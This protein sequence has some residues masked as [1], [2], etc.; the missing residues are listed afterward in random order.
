MTAA[1][2][3]ASLAL[4]LDVDDRHLLTHSVLLPLCDGE[5]R[6]MLN[7]RFAAGEGCR[8][9]VHSAALGA[10]LEVDVVVV[11]CAEGT[12]DVAVPLELAEQREQLRA[13]CD[14]MTG[15]KVRTLRVLL[16]EDNPHIQQMYAHALRRAFDPHNVRVMVEPCQDGQEAMMRVGRLP[17]VD[18]VVTDLN[19]P[20]LDGFEMV[21]RM[22]ALPAMKAV[23]V[24]VIT[25]EDPA[26][27]PRLKTLDVQAVLHKPVQLPEVVDAV[28]RLVV[29]PRGPS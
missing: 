1:I 4:R 2:P 18:L 17:P 10:P 22:R 16:V 20:V 29:D 14:L 13:L 8:V 3:K 9:T 5:L 12:V 15:R 21:R 19:M 11:R 6:V 26:T 27:E 28:R 7:H 23:P 25:A 24:V